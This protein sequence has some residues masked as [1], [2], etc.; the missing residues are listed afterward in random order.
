MK[1]KILEMLVEKLAALFEMR[2][3][4]ALAACL[5]FGYCV[6]KGTVG[7]EEVKSAF[8][9]VLGW[10]A[11]TNTTKTPETRLPDTAADG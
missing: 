4:L 8:W 3:F 6:F 1:E 7:A 11:G 2:T 10:Y 5:F 9:M